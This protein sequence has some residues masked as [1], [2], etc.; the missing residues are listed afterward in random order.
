MVRFGPCQ[1]S[2]ASA[3]P[4][5]EEVTG[6]SLLSYQNPYAG[7]PTGLALSIQDKGGDEI[8]SH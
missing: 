8:A 1:G 5:A 7:Y 3:Y 4:L 2:K 6:E